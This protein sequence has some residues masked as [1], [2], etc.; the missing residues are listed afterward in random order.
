MDFR[1]RSHGW[2]MD[3]PFRV[4]V[5]EREAG[6]RRSNGVPRAH[7]LPEKAGYAAIHDV[8]KKGESP[9]R[10]GLACVCKSDLG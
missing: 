7:V 8:M 4:V 6:S 3:I 1:R 2:D 10:D 5:C 9:R